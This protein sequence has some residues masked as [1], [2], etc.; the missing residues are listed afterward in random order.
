VAAR[1]Q[2]RDNANQ[3]E[4][5]GAKRLNA[6]GRSG[7]QRCALGAT[8]EQLGLAAAGHELAQPVG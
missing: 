6:I 7:L 3:S 8:E 2:L 1:Q 4:A 5:L